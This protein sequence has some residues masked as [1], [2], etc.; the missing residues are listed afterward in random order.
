MSQQR[1][2]V[3]ILR[4]ARARIADP[5]RWGRGWFAH[6]ERGAARDYKDP[7][8]VNWCASG[9]IC[10]EGVG[11]QSD[12]YDALVRVLPKGYDKVCVF[13]DDYGVTHADVL[14]LY[15]RAIAAVVA[16]DSEQHKPDICSAINGACAVLA[17]RGK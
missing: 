14:A 16:A 7:E 2:T 10:A 4:A 8:A 9:A 1:T 15:D 6:D 17:G 12:A 11:L 13:N 3:E 5:K